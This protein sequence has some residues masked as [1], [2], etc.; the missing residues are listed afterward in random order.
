MSSAATNLMTAEE[1]YDWTHRPENRDR[2]FELADGEVF[3]MSL[4]G[5]QHCLVCGNACGLLWMYRR[6]H[7]NGNVF[8]ND[9]GIILE[10][11]PDTVRGPDVAYYLETTTFDDQERKYSDRM[12]ALV[13]EVLSPNDR[14]GRM[15]K[16]INKF[17]EKGV[18]MVW[19][20]D[21]ES[22]TVS[23]YLPSQLPMVLEGDEEVSGQGVLLGFQ[24]KAC[25]FFAT[26]A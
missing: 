18:G 7:K 12:P 11:D 5:K 9:M 1:F 19:L 26:E 23:V 22:Q 25:E 24:C 4:P 21:P 17:L 6:Q 3:E 15:Q 2:L 20:L 14:I 16:R 10:R 13:V 8:T